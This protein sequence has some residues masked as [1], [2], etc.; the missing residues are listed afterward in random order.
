V[1]VRPVP[2][3]SEYWTSFLDLLP[4]LLSLSDPNLGLWSLD[5][6]VWP[7][8]LLALLPPLEELAAVLGLRPPLCLDS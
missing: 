7:P 5:L 8:A 4:D 6:N 2:N 1:L 3:L